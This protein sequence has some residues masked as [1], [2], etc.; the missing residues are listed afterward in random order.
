M[1]TDDAKTYLTK[2]EIPRLFESLMTGLMYHRPSDHL[3]YLI[4]CL[5]KVR[6]EGIDSIRWNYFVD[7]RRTKTPLP[8]VTPNNGKHHGSNRRTPTPKNGRKTPKHE[9][10]RREL[11]KSPVLPPIG[12]QRIKLPNVPIVFLM[13]GPG[14]GKLTQVQRLVQRY[15]GWVHLSMGDLIRH[16]IASR[17]TAEAKWDM[18]ADLVSKGEMAPEDIT[19]EL[20]IDNFKKHP[21][22]SGFI[23]EGYPRDL[24][25][26]QEYDKYIGRV[27]LVFLLDCEEALCQQRL[28]QRGQDKGRIDDNMAA[29]AKRIAFFKQNTLPAIKHYDDQG[30]LVMLDGDRDEEEVA[31]ELAALFDNIFYKK[32]ETQPESQ[33][34][35]DGISCPK[36]LPPIAAHVPRPPSGQKPVSPYRNVTSP[37]AQS[38]ETNLVSAQENGIAAEALDG[39]R[40]PGLPKCPIIFV[41]GGPGSGKRDQCKHVV[42]KYPDISHISVGEIL[43]AEVAR[44]EA[45]DNKWG[46]VR[47][48]INSGSMAPE[49]V[50]ID[51]LEKA[52]RDRS[53]SKAILV[54]GYPRNTAQLQLFNDK[55][56][57]GGYVLLLDTSEDTLT[58][59]L[60]ERGE[61]EERQ[62]SHLDAVQNR[63]TTYKN[64]TL[65]VL[66]QYDDTNKLVVIDGDRNTD[67]VSN[68]LLLWIDH[69]VYGSDKP[70]MAKPKEV[71]VSPQHSVNETREGDSAGEATY[72]EQERQPDLPQCPII[73]IT[74]G[75]GSGKREQCKHVV[76]KYPDISHISVGEILRAEVARREAEDNKWGVVRD[77]I[78]SGDTAPEDLVIDLVEKAIKE[79]SE[80]KAIIVDG[81]PRNLAQLQLF[82]DKIGGAGFMLLIDTLEERLTKKLADRGQSEER[83]DNNLDAVQNRLT[84]YKNTTLP[85]L[86]QYDDTGKLVL[87]DGE[88][89]DEDVFSVICEWID[90]IVFDKEKPHMGIL[91]SKGLPEENKVAVGEEIIEAVV[92]AEHAQSLGDMGNPYHTAQ[93]DAT[94]MSGKSDDASKGGTEGNVAVVEE[95]IEK[96]IVAE[97]DQNLGDKGNP[98]HTALL[99]TTRACEDTNEVEG[100]EL[101]DH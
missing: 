43:R 63:L 87:I 90:H 4:T 95:I 10:L 77:L 78:N 35:G 52:I 19:I 96:A 12:D 30:K 1:T 38:R 84:N 81:Y 42:E 2:R 85:V 54:D 80:A 60:A 69:L 27:D 82:N 41:A 22:A 46:V 14:S 37:Q 5:E 70:E 57:E 98:Y 33:A 93:L 18:V 32:G 26:V 47:D 97:H 91:P 76:E 48:L 15:N 16:Q 11:S 49:D 24:R 59:K 21:S 7:L 68:D 23:V 36:P 94:E 79:R 44:R 62:D 17:G 51:L 86:K 20:L 40:K 28:Y 56:G 53:E 61:D 89:G 75:P 58:R 72:M 8:P 50:V 13:G 88:A 31:F 34:A 83:S 100:T 101:V 29:I 99:E 3:H 39:G 73:F 66:K 25:Q 74:G 45:E 6:T 55:I 67:K 64:D 92:V 65:P 71:A 9:P